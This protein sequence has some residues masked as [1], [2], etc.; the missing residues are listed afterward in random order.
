MY[1]GNLREYVSAT[2][3]REAIHLEESKARDMGRFEGRK[4][5]GGMM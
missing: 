3:E 2:R 5:K 4:K 1:L